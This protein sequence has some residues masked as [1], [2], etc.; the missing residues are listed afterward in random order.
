MRRSFCV[1]TVVVFCIVSAVVAF[2]VYST[3]KTIVLR[4]YDSFPNPEHVGEFA[5]ESVFIKQ[6]LKRVKFEFVAPEAMQLLDVLHNVRSGVID[7]A[8]TGLYFW[9]HIDPAL[10]LVS[11]T[12]FSYNGF[13][14]L[15]LL[16][17]EQGK[18]LYDQLGRRH[19][20]VIIP[21]GITGM[22]VCGWWKKP[23]T[24]LADIKGKKIRIAGIAGE[25]FKRFGAITRYDIP[26]NDLCAALQKGDI[27]AV[28]WASPSDDLQQKFYTVTKHAML[29]GW[30]E[31]GTVLQ[32]IINRDVWNRLSFDMHD[33]IQRACEYS[34]VR[35]A[36]AYPILDGNAL[37][38]LKALGV[39]FH[40]WSS[41]ILNGFYSE[42]KRIIAPFRQDQL[43]DNLYRLIETNATA[44]NTHYLLQVGP[45]VTFA[46]K[47]KL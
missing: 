14:Q 12:P 27:D 42:F 36:S 13:Y 11:A 31:A 26:V 32:L 44:F 34:F 33:E 41:E 28:E 37:L 8:I 19:N 6:K 7:A 25:I 23:P 29:P 17:S 15:Q 43:F 46:Q 5:K 3:K 47:V 39:E 1:S 40:P 21:C 10:Y 35:L 22:Q 9:G 24:T 30:H 2:Y 18:K 45:L 16:S 4:V 38:H 20:I